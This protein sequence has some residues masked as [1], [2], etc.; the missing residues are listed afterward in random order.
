ML[1]CHWVSVGMSFNSFTMYILA[2]PLLIALYFGSI[3]MLDRKKK[4][5]AIFLVLYIFALFCL[6]C[7]SYIF[8]FEKAGEN[9]VLH[10]C[11]IQE[12]LF[13]ALSYAPLS[14]VI[15]YLLYPFKT[16]KRNKVLIWILLGYTLLLIVITTFVGTLVAFSNM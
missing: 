6:L 3:R 8:A 1:Q 9:W 11:P 12:Q 2:F 14:F 4:E 5:F 15:A 7:L 16:I 10:V 13:M